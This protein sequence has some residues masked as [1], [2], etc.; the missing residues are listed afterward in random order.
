MKKIIAILLSSLYL[1]KE[2]ISFYF[3]SGINKPGINLNFAKISRLNSFI[4]P[5]RK[6]AVLSASLLLLSTILSLP[7]PLFTK[8]IVDDVIY[9]SNRGMLSLIVLV[10]FFIFLIQSHLSF[11]TGYLFFRFEQDVL[12]DL[13]CQLFNQLLCFPMSFFD[14][15][16]TGYLMSRITGDVQELQI[17]FSR[18]IVDL[19]TNIL[20][21]IGGLIILFFLHWKLAL[22]SIPLLPLFLHTSRIGG[23][24]A[25][26]LNHK[27]ME[28]LANVSRILNEAISGILLTKTFVTEAK[29]TQK[30]AYSLRG[31][32]DSR[33]QL[34]VL[35]SFFSLLIGFITAIGSMLV[36]WFG[37]LEI[38]DKRLTIGEFF[39]FNA[40]LGYLY[41]P[42][43]FLSSVFIRM[44]SSMAA[45]ERVFSLFELIPENENDN[46]RIKLKQLEG[47]IDFTKVN[48]SYNGKVPVL[49]S[50]SFS[51]KSGEKIAI[52]G[53]TGAGKTTLINLILRIYQPQTG[54]IYYDGWDAGELS[55][56]SLRE[57][58][59]IV[60]QEIFLFDDTI[61]N[62]IRYGKPAAEMAEVVRIAKIAHAHEF[63]S[64]L[65]EG[66]HTRVG[67]RGVKLSVGQKQR[68]SIARALL[69]DPDLLIFDE[70]T[71]ALDPITEQA[72][73]EVLFHHTPHKTT[74]I[75]AHRLSTI[76]SAD[77]IVVLDQGQLV[78]CGTHTELVNQPGLYQQ[79]FH[80]QLHL[81]NSSPSEIS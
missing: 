43:N 65:P 37:A 21:F 75:I 27:V 10:L 14:S 28:K 73:K 13:Q 68:L 66:Y 12:F 48:F 52:V 54:Q 23:K 55:L 45:I 53:P 70:P 17:F 47:R 60:S 15:N 64:Q 63:I 77:R 24:K 34:H 9:S 36:L 30:Y 19:L 18:T 38:M 49:K 39:A 80:Q 2:D 71:S 61:L 41:G 51:I 11:F 81:K 22:I 56:R 16:Q 74:F 72:I 76:I 57:K 29:Q 26:P 3:E 35:N 1:N 50:I 69:K 78:Q 4:L 32:I 5:H 59:G 33:I 20:R 42:S 7:Q 58:M 46:G 67:E 25:K 8:Y 62:N 40:Y 6:K 44:K 79:M 31:S